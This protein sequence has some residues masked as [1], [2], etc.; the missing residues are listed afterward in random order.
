MPEVEPL[1]STHAA[2][3][4]SS[5]NGAAGD[6]GSGTAARGAGTGDGSGEP[7]KKK[8]KTATGLNVCLFFTFVLAYPRGI[9]VYFPQC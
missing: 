2:M 7:V 6:D 8:Q 9:S 3:I 5:G 4:P 1:S